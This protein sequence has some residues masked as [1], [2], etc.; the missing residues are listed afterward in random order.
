MLPPLQSTHLLAF[1]VFLV[2]SLCVLFTVSFL[3]G[4]ELSPFMWFALFTALLLF[5]S[6]VHPLLEA[7]RLNN[8]FRHEHLDFLAELRVITGDRTSRVLPLGSR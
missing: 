1:V 8:H 3:S 4:I 5:A 6:I 7:V 2:F